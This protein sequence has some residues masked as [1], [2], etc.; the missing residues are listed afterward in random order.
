MEHGPITHEEINMIDE[1]QDDYDDYEINT[2]SDLF[3]LIELRLREAKRTP[4]IK[5]AVS[6]EKLLKDSYEEAWS[7]AKEIRK[8]NPKLIELP[9]PT[10]ND[11]KNLISLRD[12]CTEARGHTET[13]PELP[14]DLVSCKK[15]AIALHKR[16]DSVARS[17]RNDGLYTIKLSG[18]WYCRLRDAMVKWPERKR[19]LT[20]VSEE[21][22]E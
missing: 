7:Y 6:K 5:G 10:P 21:P 8:A 19:R 22:T 11:E 20:E 9:P 17:M 12:W 1:I 14:D 2:L 4:L 18:K 15:V 13:P 16:S 3:R